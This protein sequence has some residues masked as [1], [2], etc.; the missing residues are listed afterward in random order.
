MGTQTHI[1]MDAIRAQM[2]AEAE[3][4]MQVGAEKLGSIQGALTSEFTFGTLA[5]ANA[6]FGSEVEAKTKDPALAETG[7][8]AV[9]T[10]LTGLV[11]D[12]L[13]TLHDSLFTLETW[14]S[15]QVPAIADG[16]NFGVEIQEHTVKSLMERRTKAKELLD[17]LH[18]WSSERGDLWG[19]AVFPVVAKKSES[20][21]SKKSTG[22]E[23]D[24]NESSESSDIA[25]SYNMVVSDAVVAIAAL[26]TQQY[27]HL[28]SVLQFV[29]K[30][31]AVVL[32]QIEKNSDKLKDPRGELGGNDGGMS[33]F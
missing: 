9:V 1:N 26:D 33:M 14:L 29:W 19:K 31:Y 6:Q 25:T 17:S 30:T 2:D 20:K 10:R 3:R 12:E 27:F 32:D 28:K 7:V 5:E 15:L 24:T 13:A 23:K 22:G 21:G 16:N 4:V 8:N 18:K 11:R